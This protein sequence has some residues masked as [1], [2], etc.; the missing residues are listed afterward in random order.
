[1]MGCFDRPRPALAVVGFF[2]AAVLG[3]GCSGQIGTVPGKTDPQNSGSGGS[4]GPGVTP[5]PCAAD[6]G[7]APPRLWRLN[8]TQYRNVVHDVFG[9]GITVPL[10][11]S[12]A[13]SAGSEA[14]TRVERHLVV[15]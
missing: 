13:I 8:D 14:L 6:T 11:V 7:F 15:R 10:D 5:V 3:L 12:E 2:V 4:T 1:M 9:A